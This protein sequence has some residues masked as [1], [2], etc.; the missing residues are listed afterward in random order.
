MPEIVLLHK[1]HEGTA[2]D[3]ADFRASV[4]HLT[5]SAR[6]WLLFALNRS[7]QTILGP[8]SCATSRLGGRGNAARK[9]IEPIFVQNP[10]LHGFALRACANREHIRM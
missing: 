10:K 3:E 7:H 5:P 9:R 6:A 8:P 1:A 4:S 2:K